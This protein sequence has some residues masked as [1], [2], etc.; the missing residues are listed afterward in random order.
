MIVAEDD[1]APAGLVN[2]VVFERMAAGVGGC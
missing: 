1:D 2:V